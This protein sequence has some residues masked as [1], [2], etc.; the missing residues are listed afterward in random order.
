MSDNESENIVETGLQGNSPTEND[1]KS[2][3]LKMM[4]DFKTDI[5]ANV[6]ETVA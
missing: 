6:Q 2:V 5:L 1:F 4:S 3:M